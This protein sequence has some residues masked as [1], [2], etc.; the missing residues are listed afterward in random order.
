M[1]KLPV[2]IQTFENIRKYPNREVQQAILT[3]LAATFLRK[4]TFDVHV[5]IEKD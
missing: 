3:Q 4:G 2:S 1:K 5:R